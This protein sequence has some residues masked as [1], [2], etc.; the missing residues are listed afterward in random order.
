MLNFYPTP[1]ALCL[2]LSCIMMSSAVHATPAIATES[3]AHGLTDGMGLHP[4]IHELTELATAE[5]TPSFTMPSDAKLDRLASDVLWTRLLMYPDGKDKSSMADASFFLAKNGRTSP[6]AELLANLRQF[7]DVQTARDFICRYPARTHWLAKQLPQ[8]GQMAEAMPCAEF[9][10][11]FA[12]MDV[13]RMSLIYAEEHIN[14]IGSAFAHTLIRLDTKRSLAEDD[15][16]YAYSLNFANQTTPAAGENTL[17]DSVQG[18]S[19]A[20][21]TLENY[22]EK[23]NKYLVRDG[24]DIWQYQIDLNQDEIDQIMRH[25][26]EIRDKVRYYRFLNNNCAT[27]VL[28]FVDLVRPNARILASAG[29]ITSPAEATQVMGRSGVLVTKKFIPAVKTLTQ[30]RLNHGNAFSAEELIPSR[31]D[32]TDEGTKT[33]RMSIYAGHDGGGDFIGISGRGA[34]QD[35]LDRPQGKRDFLS[36][37]IMAADLRIQEDELKLHKATLLD[38]KTLNPIG[39]SY[40]GKSWRL[41]TGLTQ[42]VDGVQAEDHLVAQ[43]EGGLGY[44]VSF[45]G[46]QR[47]TAEMPRGLCYGFGTA[48]AQL[49]RVAKGW[50]ASVGVQAGCVY[51]ATDRVRIQADAYTP[52]WYHDSTGYWQPALTTAIQYDLSANHAVRLSYHWQDNRHDIDNG[53]KVALLKYF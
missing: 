52:Y 14:R 45:G 31:N 20:E 26:W 3:V 30:A 47:G 49:G 36:V 22:E 17:L 38:I 42:V 25:V 2:A 35:L 41:H 46:M 18:R 33:H 51:Y 16:A 27:E 9:E 24:R 32:P 19:K 44:S 34:Y 21:L 43:T 15:P 5:P 6:R 37:E 50:R 12:N 23:Q 40:A 7:E 8:I 48:A 1:S 13:R 53:Y 28:R 39:S 4:V 10:A 11:W 29:R